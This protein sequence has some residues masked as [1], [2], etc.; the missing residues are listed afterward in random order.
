M[1]I[2]FHT[3]NLKDPNQALSKIIH[4]NSYVDKDF[5]SFFQIVLSPIT[6]LSIT[7]P[8]SIL[9]N[10]REKKLQKSSEYFQE[11]LRDGALVSHHKAMVSIR[12]PRTPVVS[13]ALISSYSV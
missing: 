3:C 6:H 11:N 5:Y 13:H 7:G 8:L 10:K 9:K 12:H 1:I 2:I 4:N